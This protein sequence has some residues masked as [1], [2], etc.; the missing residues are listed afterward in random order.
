[1]TAENLP[2]DFID[3]E[4]L[5]RL[6]KQA[7]DKQEKAVQKEASDREDRIKKLA[8]DLI[9]MIRKQII[10]KTKEAALRG[11]S[12]VTVSSMDNGLGIR[13]EGWKRACWSVI[14]EYREAGNKLRLELESTEHVPGSDE[15][16]HSYTELSLVASFGPKEEKINPW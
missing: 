1:M 6:R 11:C 10:E 2:G 14:Y 15:Y 7:L 4:E 12:S 3:I 9:P 5:N 16:S 8:N 13:T